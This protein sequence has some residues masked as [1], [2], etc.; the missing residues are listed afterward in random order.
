MARDTGTAS[1]TSGTGPKS[2]NIGRTATDMMIVFKGPNILPSES[3]IAGGSQYA[4]PDNNT[5]ADSTKAIKVRNLSGTTILEG[6]WTSF[7]G[8]YANFNITTQTGSVP[9]M[10][11]NFE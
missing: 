5:V 9:Q 4:F 7:S 6:T 11:L 1:F 10:L 8:N 3:Y 2:I